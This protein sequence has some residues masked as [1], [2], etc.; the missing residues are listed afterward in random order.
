MYASGVLIVMRGTLMP[1][2]RHH[3][4]PA[5]RRPLGRSVLLAATLL[6]GL[7]VVAPTASGVTI[8]RVWHGNIGTGAYY[9][10]MTIW[11]YLTGNGFSHLTVKHLIP[12]RTYSVRVWSGT[13][14]HPGRAA[15]SLPGIRTSATGT[16][17]RYNALSST[18]LDTIWR[19]AH[20]GPISIRLVYGSSV[21][22]ANLTFPVATRIVFS[23][24]G[25]NLPVVMPP[26][27]TTTFPYCN[28]AMYTEALSQPGEPGVTMLFAHA[29]TG[30]FL[31][32]LLQSRIN[33]GSAMIGKYIRVYTSNS[34]VY[35]YRVT[36]VRR[37]LTSVQSAFSTWTPQ[38]WLQT[39]EGPNASS[40]KLVIVAK[41]IS[42]AKT[43][44][45]AS[46][47]RAHPVVCR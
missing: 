14:A 30:M 10:Q 28:V 2:V 22:C 24:E 20:S 37:H 5:G 43:T 4:R 39:S 18:Q 8:R 38:L 3:S 15:L 31:P 25:I 26:G 29:R 44:Y 45:A 11:A 23:Y 33:G 46:H 40:L 19:Y 16:A 47:P 12:S 32:L 41:Y 42:V 21:R 35:T 36:A 9:G 13:C 17:D 27:G 7:M 34:R 6:L 1:P